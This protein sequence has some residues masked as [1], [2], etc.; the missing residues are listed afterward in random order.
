MGDNMNRQ[1]VTVA[2][3]CILAV[4]MVAAAMPAAALEIDEEQTNTSL[5]YELVVPER[6]MQSFKVDN[7]FVHEIDIYLDVTNVSTLDV[8]IDSDTDPD[9]GVIV[10]KYDWDVSEWEVGWHTWDISGGAELIADKTYYLNVWPSN[11]I[12]DYGKKWHIYGSTGD[13][14][15]T[16][17]PRGMAYRV[18]S[19]GNIYEIES[20]YADG[21]FRIYTEQDTQP[22]DPPTVSDPSPSDG[23]TNYHRDA[24]LAVNVS[25][26]NS[27]TVTI[28][29]YD[30][31]NGLTI[32]SDT[33]Y[34]GDGVARVTWAG[35]DPAS[36]YSWYV[37]AD[38]GSTTTESSQW[39]FTTSGTGGNSVPE[40]SDP[41][42]SDGAV[43]VNT[44]VNMSVDVADADGDTVTVS[45]NDASDGSLLG[46]STVNGNGT[47]SISWMAD[48]GTGYRWFAVADD[49]T[50]SVKSDI[51]SFETTGT[52]PV[53]SSTP[54]VSLGQ[55][56]TLLAVGAAVIGG[57]V[58]VIKRRKG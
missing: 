42:P 48:A 16:P 23:Q 49:G 8:W 32:G 1:I 5:S 54:D 13:P 19:D 36:E 46:T 44:S 37:T 52:P 26:P 7:K 21:A 10:R 53:S 6:G 41:Q 38:D 28:W 58:I 18:A 39:S 43:D 35:L 11:I 24:P 40:L 56:M 4:A 47:A 14:S 15:G 9:N 51:W 22:N 12:P 2:L 55:G 25:D 45:F 27:D 20:G 30:A 17:Y 50:D 29:F 3:S 34:G 33:V 57:S 31:V